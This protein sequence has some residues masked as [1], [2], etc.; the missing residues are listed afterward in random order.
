MLV[1]LRNTHRDKR[2]HTSHVVVSL[3]MNTHQIMGNE[4]AEENPE[5]VVAIGVQDG[6]ISTEETV[7]DVTG[8]GLQN[9]LTNAI[10]IPDTFGTTGKE[11]V[12]FS[13]LGVERVV[14]RTVD[15]TDQEA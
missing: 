7:G 5:Q 10:S 14:A 8:V 2:R 4:L 1:L 12:G 15:L 13:P 11:A 6:I 3:T 9:W